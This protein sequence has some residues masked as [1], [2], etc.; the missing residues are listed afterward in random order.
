MIIIE[1]TEGRGRTCAVRPSHGILPQVAVRQVAGDGSETRAYPIAHLPSQ[2]RGRDLAIEDLY[3]QDPRHKAIS[4]PFEV[5]W[6]LQHVAM[7]QV[8]RSGSCCSALFACA[9]QVERASTDVR[10][11]VQICNAGRGGRVRSVASSSVAVPGATGSAAAPTFDMTLGD[12]AFWAP[13]AAR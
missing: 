11:Q 4:R 5:D 9:V 6:N 10:F 3:V 8:P 1:V 12:S 2:D 7:S 13:A